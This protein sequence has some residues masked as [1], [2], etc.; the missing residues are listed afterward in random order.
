V[1]GRQAQ[2][3]SSSEGVNLRRGFR[4]TVNHKPGHNLKPNRIGV[5]G[6][7]LLALSPLILECSSA[8]ASTN[9]V[10][11]LSANYTMTAGGSGDTY[12]RTPTAIVS[13]QDQVQ[14][15]ITGRVHWEVSQTETNRIGSLI[16]SSAQPTASGSWHDYV[17]PFTKYA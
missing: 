7:T 3:T 16:S 5:S 10:G 12:D 1:F 2:S 6:L 4:S 9:R 13:S 14:T 8:L 15:S 11:V 17:Y